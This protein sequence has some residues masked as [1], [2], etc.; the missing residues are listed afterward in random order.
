MDDK[1]LKLQLL[2]TTNALACLVSYLSV[3]LGVLATKDLLDKIYGTESTSKAFK[4]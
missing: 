1:E 2:R 3:E 4:D